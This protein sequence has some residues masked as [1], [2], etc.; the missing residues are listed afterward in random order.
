LR[1]HGSSLLSLL[2]SEGQQA[3]EITTV[4]MQFVRRHAAAQVT[5]LH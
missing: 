1:R 3:K 4:G 2:S 5:F